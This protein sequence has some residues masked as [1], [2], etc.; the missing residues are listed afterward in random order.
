LDLKALAGHGLYFSWNPFTSLGFG[1]YLIAVAI[2]PGVTLGHYNTE[3]PRPA[4]NSYNVAQ[5]VLSQQ[6]GLVY[7]WRA[8][9]DRALVIRDISVLTDNGRVPTQNPASSLGM[10]GRRASDAVSVKVDVRHDWMSCNS[11]PRQ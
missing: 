10:F 4:D 8:A 7:W 11:I 1:Y 3:D 9:N 5:L 2:P 6:K